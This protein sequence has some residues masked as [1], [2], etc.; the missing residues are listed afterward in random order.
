M[1]APTGNKNSLRHGLT[2]G[3]LPTGTA[4][5]TRT[6]NALRAAIEDALTVA[7]REIGIVEAAAIQSACRWERHA[8]LAQR[9]LRKET[10]LDPDQ[11]LA[12]SREIARASSER[13]K[14]LDRLKL[15]HAPGANPWAVLDAPSRNAPTAPSSPNAS[16][17]K[18]SGQEGMP[19]NTTTEPAP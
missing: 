18:P 10:G 11:K 1:P 15:D 8:L 17:A 4:Y 16:D 3:T 7:G 13:D 5:V 19:T 14:C 2:T 9:W 12:F 6:I